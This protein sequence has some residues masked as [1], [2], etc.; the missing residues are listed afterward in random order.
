MEAFKNVLASFFEGDELNLELISAGAQCWAVRHPSQRHL[1]LEFGMENVLVIC[2]YF[3]A[4]GGN[5]CSLVLKRFPHCFSLYCW[6]SDIIY[7]ASRLE[8]A[9]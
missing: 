9:S 3:D 5:K 2:K 6:R 7:L 4:A 1:V 8:L